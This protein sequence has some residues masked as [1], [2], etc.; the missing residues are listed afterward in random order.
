MFDIEEVSEGKCGFSRLSQI[1]IA[2]FLSGT[3]IKYKKN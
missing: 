2:V 3:G 1:D